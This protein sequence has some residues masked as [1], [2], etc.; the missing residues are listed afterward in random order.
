[1][2]TS[3][4]PAEFSRK[5]ASLPKTIDR[6]TKDVVKNNASLAKRNAEGELRSA[7]KGSNRL[8][9]AGALVRA[10]ESRQVVGRA[11]A[12]LKVAVIPEA[13]QARILV[14]AVGPWQLIES[15]TK[16]HFIGPA[17][18]DK[19]IANGKSGRKT[20]KAR[21]GRAKAL[22]TPFGLKRWVETP[23]TKGKHPWRKAF[24]KTQRQIGDP[25]KRIVVDAVRKAL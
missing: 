3:K 11:G 9:N 19:G 6:A 22:R 7:T 17:G 25:S 23:G 8:S 24:V 4:T 15:P 20:E 1:M 14:S 18:F 2:G 5:I 16:R 10:G 12:S 13:N 21:Q